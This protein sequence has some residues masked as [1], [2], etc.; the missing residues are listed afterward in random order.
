[1]QMKKIEEN[2]K[3]ALELLEQMMKDE[4]K[5]DEDIPRQ[6]NEFKENPY[7]GQNP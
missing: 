7:R 3:K 2:R 1:M 4:E 6:S 5:L